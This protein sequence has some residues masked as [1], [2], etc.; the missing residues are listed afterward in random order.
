VPA[1][2]LV[3]APPPPIRPDRPCAALERQIEGEPALRVLGLFAP[4]GYGKTCALRAWWTRR[5][6]PRGWVQVP[7][8][9]KLARGA[10]E[11]ASRSVQGGWLVVDGVERLDPAAVAALEDCIQGG[12]SVRFIV[13]GR[14][15]RTLPLAPWRSQGLLRALDARALTLDPDGWAEAG[16]PGRCED[17]AGWWGASL[18][19]LQP[20][21]IWDAEL[22]AWLRAAW[23]EELDGPTLGQLGLVALLGVATPELVAVAAGVPLGQAQAMLAAFGNAVLPVQATPEGLR[24]APRIRPHVLRAWRARQP[25]AWAQAVSRSVPALLAQNLPEAAGRVALEAEDAAQQEAVL[26]AAGFRLLYG[27]DRELLRSLLTCR[28]RRDAPGDPGALLEAAWQVEAA[29]VPH[30]VERELMAVRGA[31]NGEGLAVADALLGSVAWQ[32][33]QFARARTSASSA[34]VGFPSDLHP[35]A[36]LARWTLGGCELQDGRFAEAERALTHA[37]ACAVRDGLPRAQLQVWRRLALLAELREDEPALA[38]A[39]GEF[40]RTLATISEDPWGTDTLARL[41]ATRALRRLDVGAARTALAAGAPAGSRYGAPESF[42]HHVLSA[43]I[44]WVEGAA[45]ALEAEVAWV[46]AE[47]VQRFH[48]LKRRADALLPR[49]ALRARRADSAGL[50]KLVAEVA[51]EPWPEGI[52]RSRRDLLL[53]GA[54]LL[55]AGRLDAAALTRRARAWRGVGHVALARQ[56]ELLAALGRPKPDLPALLAHVRESAAHQCRLDYLWLASRSVGPLERLLSSPELARDEVTRP[57]L[58][59]LVQRLLGEAGAGAAASGAAA[60]EPGAPGG[61]FAPPADLTE[62]EWEILRLIGQ[63]FT[64]DQIAERLF[65]SV[66]T[67]KT[68]INHVYAKLGITSRSEA[69]MRARQLAAAPPLAAAGQG[70]RS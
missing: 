59:D 55:A 37:L 38:Q 28:P 16:V 62:R 21:G 51:A 31:M 13:S 70:G 67:V 68:H 65:V 33:D 22:D 49:L 5:P 17:W 10:L 15:G 66:A 56:A 6:G 8:R 41:E 19:A 34:L 14:H 54:E 63:R 36:A 57:F 18:A 61:A 29:H 45:A 1:P 7:A 4:G 24:L 64:N 69:V 46:E 42:P 11:R 3:S 35:A 60:V 12:E 48:S 9:G 44:A 53:A 20:M 58:R 47:L 25:E 39:V 26:R 27:P 40:R 52:A 2:T 43:T 50:R 32:Y 23:L 30:Q